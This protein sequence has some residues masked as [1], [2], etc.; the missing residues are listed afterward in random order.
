MCRCVI[1]R[2]HHIEDL[3]VIMNEMGE[4]AY[5]QV[6]YT[7]YNLWIIFWEKWTN[8]H[9]WHRS[10]TS[11]TRSANCYEGNGQRCRCVFLITCWSTGTVRQ[12]H[13]ERKMR[14]K[15]FIVVLFFFFFFFWVGLLMDMYICPFRPYFNHCMPISAKNLLH[16]L[17]PLSYSNRA[18]PVQQLHRT[19]ACSLWL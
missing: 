17:G 6:E 14:T 2:L 12:C 11:D 19:E 1:V 10:A 3:Q 5:V 4:C 15:C 8:V 16:I 18:A 13:I 7:P 9:I